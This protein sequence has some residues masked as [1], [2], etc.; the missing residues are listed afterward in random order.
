[1]KAPI[2]IDHAL[3]D[4]QL[5]GAALGDL[6]TWQ[7]WIAVLKASF[8]VT[9]SRTERR[10]FVAVAGRRRPPKQ[11]V[12]ELWAIVG[13]RAGKSRVAAAI[14]VYI[15]CF[16]QHDLDPGE[17][18]YVLCLA[19]TAAQAKTVFDYAEAFLRSSPVLRTMIETVTQ[20]EIR[21]TNGVT[22]AIHVSSYRH[23]R[24]KTLLAVI[25][26]EISYWR[27][28]DSANPDREVL[29]AVSPSLASTG[30]ML[31]AISSPYRKLGVLYERHRDYYGQD[32]DSVLVIS[33]P[34]RALNPTIDQKIID[35]AHKDDPE[36]ARAEWDAEFRTDISALF[37]DQVL[38]DAVD[39]SRPL[40]L[41]PRKGT[42][43][44]AF[45]DASAGRHDSFTVCIGH[46]EGERFI[47]D[48]LRGYAAPFDPRTAAGE[49][50]A[51]ARS[52]RCSKIVGDAF[53]GEW[54]AA[55]F[56]DAGIR[57]ETS[58]LNKS[59]LYLEAL[60]PFN[61]G[62]VNIP[63]HDRL[64]RE[65][66]LLERRVSRSG[67]DAVDHPRNG[68]DDHAN[69][70]CGAL[71]VTLNDTRRPKLLLGHIHAYASERDACPQCRRERGEQR[72]RI[73][74]AKVAERDIEREGI[75][76]R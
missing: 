74:I 60:A 45:T 5:L 33:A 39:Y 76:L 4:P 26:D 54:V 9:L 59:A 15:A 51:L 10:A 67:K 65:L 63:A 13:R 36:A 24:G 20:D 30:G 58:P 31:V 7:V 71:Y 25:A 34:T 21:L 46:A 28:D 56:K 3:A 50:A 48:V 55:A 32:D 75:R 27:S 6:T 68:A 73:R 47:C 66:R 2:S 1:M 70:L 41:P 42:R 64:L 57:Y 22:I 16:F 43:Y 23:V 14:A 40:E 49:F 8:G 44:C 61:R 62:L 35:K 72:H 17:I 29:R 69:A 19:A 12:A 37:T 52:Y 11:K 38:D 53:A 18:G